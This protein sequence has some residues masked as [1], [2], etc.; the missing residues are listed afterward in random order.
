[1]RAPAIRPRLGDRFSYTTSSNVEV[2]FTVVMISDGGFSLAHPGIPIDGVPPIME[3]N[4]IPWTNL[5]S[6]LADF[7]EV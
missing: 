1:M 3:I 7:K 2:L 4:H 5:E 6:F